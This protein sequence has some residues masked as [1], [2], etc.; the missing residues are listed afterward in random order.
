MKTK[1]P[2][3]RK[4]GL[5]VS[6]WVCCALN[7]PAQ[8]AP[9][10]TTQPTNQTVLAGSNVT[11]SLAAA[12]TGPLIWQWRFNGTNL[13]NGIISTVAGTNAAGSSGDGGAAV[14]ASLDYPGGVALDAAG[15]L[16]IADAG[17]NR[18]RKVDVNGFISTVAGKSASGYAG[19]GGAANNASL[20]FP[21]AVAVDAGG[22][23][24]IADQY[25]QRI[26][27]V[28]TNGVITTVAGNGTN[29]YSGDSGAATN[30]SLNYPAGVAV[31]AAGNLYIADQY[32]QR[33][34][35]VDAGGV[36]TTVAG[37]GNLG[38]SGDGG[39]AAGANLADPGGVAFDASGNLYIA[40][41]FNQRIRK[42]DTNGIITTVAGSG[43]AA[44]AGDGGAATKA[45][46]F[47]P[48][49]AGLN[50]G[51]YLYIA[52]S[53]QR[54]RK[55][56]TNGIITTVAG[57]GAAAF[58]GD[59]GAATNASLNSPVSVALDGSGNVY[60]ADQYNQR[61]RKVLLYASYPALTLNG[62]AASNA[63]S[64]SVV[65]SN[66]YGS[67][68]SAV[69]TLT[70][71]SPPSILVQPASQG[72][73]AGSNAT[74]N[75][76][77]AGTTPF[78]YSWYFNATN[79]LQSGPASAL[80]V[81]GFSTNDAGSYTVVVTN[82]YGGVTSQVAA[83]TLAFA[84]SVATQ[85]ASQTNLEGTSVLFTVA[86]GGTGPF[87]YQWQFNGVNLPNNIITTVAGNGSQGPY[88]EGGAAT[89]SS[90]YS[91]SGVALDAAGNLY[92]ADR[93]NNRIREVGANGII[94]TVAG[95][96]T[97]GY[98]GDGGAATNAN[99]NSPYGVAVDSSGNLYVADTGNHRIRKVAAN[100]VIST[101]AGKGT[102][103]YSGDGG[104][105]T[106]ASLNSPYGLAVDSS[107]SLYVADTGNQRIRKVA[108]SGSISTVAGKGGAGYTGDNG[109]ATNANVNSP[110]G[111]ALDAFGNLYIADRSNNRIRKVATNGIIT[112]VAGET[113]AGYSGDGGAAT[114]AS[115]YYPG[116]VAVDLSGDLYIADT[117]NNGI[118]F[119]N[120]NG[121]ITT[122]AGN[123]A[124]GYSGDG[125]AATN[126][127]LD[128]PSGAALDA[129]GNLYIADY[130]NYRIR[131]VHFAGLPEIT[132][133]NAGA[134]NAG[135][136][137]VVVTSPY[138]SVTSAVAAL[139]VLLP[140]TILVQPV[141]RGVLPGGSAT[142]SVTA[143]GT[144]PLDYLWY[145]NGASL[146]Q[147]GTNPVL[148]LSGMNTG[149][150]GQY[151]VVVTNIY[152]SATSQV[153]TLAFPPVLTAQPASQAVFPGT[154]VSFIAAPGGVGPFSYQWQLNGTNLPNGIITT[155]AGN[156]GGAYAGDGGAA[157]NASLYYPQ[158]VAVDSIGNLYVADTGNNRV[159]KVAASG[160][161]S[162]VAGNGSANYTGDGS[163]ATNAS[164]YY[165]YGVAVDSVGNLYIA[166]T[167]N[168]SIRKVSA[169]GII[170]TVAGNGSGTY[171][172]DGGAATN[173]SLYFPYSVAVDAAGN[174]Y[175][176]DTYNNVIRQVAANGIINTVAGNGTNGYSGDSGAATNASLA[177]PGGVA[178]DASGNLYIADSGNN[179]VRQVATNGII[180]TLAGNGSASYAG[181]GGAAANAGLYDP[182]G[183]A[184]DAFGNLYVADCDNQLIRKVDTNGI[185]TTLAGNGSATYA[186]DGGAAT[187]AS[188][189]YAGGAALDSAGNLYIADTDNNRIRT[190]LLDA[191]HPALQLN[192]VGAANAGNYT[193]V[194][195]SPYGS[196]T[197]AVA[198]LEVA[199]A[200]P[201]IVTFDGS[202]GFL[203][204]Q[205][206]F[207]VLAAA[208]RTIAVDGSSNLVDWT[209][210]FTNAIGGGLFY[211]SDSAWTNYP[212]RFYRARLP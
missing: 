135:S 37:N 79:L 147:D 159:R 104:T 8:T 127:G 2:V 165:P 131:E 109:A 150:V 209:P 191:S 152:G 192:Y 149:N 75:V 163:A 205:F 186:G 103:A 162:T 30:A 97:N 58:A 108:A 12:G 118:R 17:N 32:N 210:L 66:A 78:Y 173:A 176:A 73:L 105:A 98:S 65:I 46:L 190:V 172:G 129:L 146:V 43:T 175:I 100:G 208:S 1:K 120:T 148:S 115:L 35:R 170:V 164:L 14:S 167:Y 157:T 151:T 93:G 119:V 90:L 5:A 211:F 160:I 143:T 141:S 45:S 144:P 57:N 54:I 179:R 96:G 9:T 112:T 15:N 11:F 206:G 7:L 31:D 184:L 204:G 16:Y 81:Q 6:A 94:S 91:P 86:A 60:I 77:A 72:V 3:W 122:A 114:S 133:T 202:F 212:A 59:G 28:N 193:V 101:V 27:K 117:D 82:A 156:G 62:V 113:G 38:Y 92:I 180:A 124:A 140:P 194:V 84:P 168:N 26:R 10:I 155:V 181:D 71:A 161:I 50:G 102:A 53:S 128:L 44:F 51:G 83:L 139:T 74:L 195:T 178:V 185:I 19:D 188:L 207:N 40:D 63:G 107:G 189:N 55:V 39:A 13:P 20:N 64:Y 116:G 183:L 80:A 142:L 24:Y 126:A 123:G 198:A 203:A 197:S 41:Q 125:G 153:A 52:D 166:D 69:A 4:L 23:L 47:Y 87:T 110:Y 25:N 21:A 48:A 201:Q 137:T 187:N 29:G 171:A 76:T 145:V 158:A 36:I 199:V 70:V 177:F 18:I 95:N 67:K 200:T 68:T 49:A 22:N 169:N 56:D 42:M 132:T 136:Y 121:I 33:V 34:R 154:N 182:L 89:N 138:G 130:S 196:V 106:N 174:L 61:I 85:P 111:V 134:N 88:V 99:L